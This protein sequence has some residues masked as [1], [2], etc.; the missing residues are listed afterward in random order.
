M[1]TLHWL[2][3][4]CHYVK[5]DKRCPGARSVRCEK[6]NMPGGGV[7]LLVCNQSTSIAQKADFKVCICNQNKQKRVSYRMHDVA[8]IFLFDNQKLHDRQTKFRIIYLVA[9]E[10]AGVE[11]RIIWSATHECE[12][13][14]TKRSLC[15]KSHQ[16]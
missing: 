15:N 3:F 14:V 10:A 13:H 1:I 12:L 6:F 11:A 8:C 7:F 2:D 9:T 4:T 5:F 16:L